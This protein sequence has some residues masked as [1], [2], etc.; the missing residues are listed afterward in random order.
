MPSI[1]VPDYEGGSLPN[2]MSELEN[3]L[4]GSAPAPRLNPD[5]A[6]SIPEAS[7]YVLFL[8]DG[9]GT[10]QL[11]HPAASPLKGALRGSIDA[12]FPATTTVSLATI[13]TG[14]PPSQHGLLGYQSWLP[15]VDDR[16]VNT[17]KWTTLWGEPI[18]Y[19]TTAFL[20]SPNLWER[21]TQAGVDPITVQP[22]NFLGSPLSKALY[23]GCRIEPAFTLEEMVEATV[24]LA[25]E[26]NRL[27]FSYLP[28]VDFAAHVHGQESAEYGEALATVAWAW[29]QA[30]ARL[31]DGAVMV[32]TAD[33][34]HLDFPKDRQVKIPKAAHDGRVFYGDARAVF[35]LGDGAPLADDLPAAWFPIEDVAG[36]WGPEPRHPAFE[37]RAPDGVLVA[38]DDRLLLHHRADDRLIGNHGALTEAERLI[39][40]LI[41]G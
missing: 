34:G 16:V 6:A 3:R 29:E 14:L 40:L 32:G 7:T 27:I 23:R 37:D 15:D 24:Q 39:P 36:W 31:P 1:T 30:S 5:L 11:D 35:V 13:A 22:G 8:F 4:T 20:P 25:E 33:H 38:E 26:P 41:A 21:L 10:L 18:E 19:D 9:L 2:L 28:H 17:I 12:P